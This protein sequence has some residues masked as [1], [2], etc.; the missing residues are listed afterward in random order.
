MVSGS[1]S[2]SSAERHR[3]ATAHLLL[4]AADLAIA[5]PAECALEIWQAERCHPVPGTPPHVIGIA[6]WRGAPLPLVDLATALGL[7]AGRRPALEGRRCAVISASSYVV[8]LVVEA[9][10]GVAEVALDE[11]RPP[12]VVNVGRLAELAAAEIDTPDGG[13]AAVLDLG[14]FLDAARVRS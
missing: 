3:G 1:P 4:R 8:G 10:M 9:T 7:R 11:A 13:V 12:A 6:S 2:T 5:V 14:A